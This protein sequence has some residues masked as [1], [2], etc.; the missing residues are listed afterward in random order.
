MT[1]Q[2]PSYARPGWIAC[3]VA[4]WLIVAHLAHVE[5]HN[6]GLLGHMVST[7]ALLLVEVDVLPDD[8]AVVVLFACGVHSNLTF[9]IDHLVEK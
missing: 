3:Q 5:L 2:S 7:A 6:V 1:K 9:D 4:L 8:V